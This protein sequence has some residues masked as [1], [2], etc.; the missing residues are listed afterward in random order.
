[1]TLQSSMLEEFPHFFKDRL[2][3]GWLSSFKCRDE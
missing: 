2:G 3:Y 1:M